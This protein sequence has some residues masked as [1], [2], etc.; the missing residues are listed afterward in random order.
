MASKVALS[1]TSLSSQHHDQHHHHH[2]ETS[3]SEA[4][5]HEC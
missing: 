1:N 4:T 3:T 5:D 2:D